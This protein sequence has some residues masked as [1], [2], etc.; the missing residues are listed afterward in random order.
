[1]FVRTKTVRGREYAYLV[2]NIW[3]K[4]GPRQK[5]VK[6]IGAVVTVPYTRDVSFKTFLH[7]LTIDDLFKKGIN[8]VYN[9][10]VKRELARHGFEALDND[11]LRFENIIVN[12]KKMFVKKNKKKI[13]IKMNE[14]FLCRETLE[15]LF[16]HTK[17]EDESGKALAED[18]LGAGISIEKGIFV[19][20]YKALKSST[21]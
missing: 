16:A 10:L 7:P 14:G 3:T 17:L 12:L 6:Y 19:R 1:M 9:A 13:A 8:E 21:I 11:I 5:T 4:K 20:I 2:R 18:I 15:R